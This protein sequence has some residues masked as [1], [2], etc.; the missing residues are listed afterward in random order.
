MNPRRTLLPKLFRAFAAADI[1]WCILRNQQQL[2]EESDS[3]VDLLT[4][5]AALPVALQRSRIVA[6]ECGLTLVQHARFINHTL[7]FWDRQQHFVRIDFDTEQR[8][9]RYPVLAADT[10]LAARQAQEDYYVP[11][12]AHEAMILLTQ[13]LWRGQL[14]E[15]YAH[16]LQEL[17]QTLQTSPAAALEWAKISALDFKRFTGPDASPLLADLRREL[18]AACW[19]RPA[20]A[21]RCLNYWVSD[22]CRLWSRLRQPPGLSIAASGITVTEAEALGQRL[23]ILFP[24]NKSR[25]VT[26]PLPCD[27]VRR[28]R[29]RGGL[30][31]ACLSGGADVRARSDS[32]A[33]FHWRRAGE[34]QYAFHHAA[35]GRSGTGG[36]VADFSAFICEVLAAQQNRLSPG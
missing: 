24:V 2:F 9:K 14:S 6:Q 13:A 1:P 12:P 7:V 29:F 18:R 17:G 8:W 19:R 3:D 5:P 15:R 20:R 33:D 25:I 10:V 28:V 21:W 16:R 34:G 31:V 11:H 26:A 22:A 27:E 30:V 4:T 35:S 32:E 23:R 36:D